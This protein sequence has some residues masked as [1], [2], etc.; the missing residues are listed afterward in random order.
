MFEVCYCGLSD[1]ERTPEIDRDFGP[2]NVEKAGMG[3]TEVH[4]KLRKSQI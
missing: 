1:F 2:K 4:E 3:L